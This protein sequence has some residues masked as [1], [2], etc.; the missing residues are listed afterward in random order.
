[1]L[2]K[3]TPAWVDGRNC[4]RTDGSKAADVQEIK[5]NREPLPTGKRALARI[6]SFLALM[7]LAPEV[8]SE[9]SEMPHGQ[10]GPRSTERA[11]RPRCVWTDPGPGTSKATRKRKRNTEHPD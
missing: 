10:S 5:W 11:C 8:R 9:V 7:S 4:K 1:M 6:G 3:L 2:K